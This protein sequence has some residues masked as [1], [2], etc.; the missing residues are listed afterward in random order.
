MVGIALLAQL[1]TN[2]QSTPFIL[3]LVS[4]WHFNL[5]YSKFEGYLFSAFY[6]KNLRFN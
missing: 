4:H 2:A 6:V 1:E 3:F 5:Q